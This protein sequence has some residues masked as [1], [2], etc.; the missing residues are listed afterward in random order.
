MR[1][2]ITL[3]AFFAIS[4]FSLSIFSQVATTYSFSQVDVGYNGISGG[5]LL[6]DDVTDNMDDETYGPISIPTFVFDGVAYDKIFVSSNGFITFGGTL[7]ADYLDYAPISYGE[8]YNGVISGFG[9]DLNYSELAGATIRCN[10]QGTDFVIQWRNVAR[11]AVSDAERFSF[12]IRLDTTTN[13]ITVTYGTTITPGDDQ[14]YPEIGIRGPDSN[15]PVNVNNREVLPFSGA[16]VNSTPGTNEFSTCVFDVN[17]PGTEPAVGTQFIWTPIGIDMQAAGLSLPGTGGCYG[18]NE[19]VSVLIRNVSG[20]VHDFATDP[21]T[22]YASASGPNPATFAPVII[23]TG[24]LAVNATQAVVVS[25]NYDMTNYGI[26]SFNA[27]TTLAGDAHLTN[28]AMAAVTRESYNPSFDS[29]P[30]VSFCGPDTATLNGFATAHDYNLTFSNFTNDNIPDDNPT[31]GFTNIIVPAVASGV[32]ASDVTVVVHGITHAYDSDFAIY[33]RAPDMSEIILSDHNLGENY[34][35][36]YFSDTATVP[37]ASGTAPYTGSFLPDFSFSGLTGTANGTWR[38]TC[39]DDVA[40]DA[41]VLEGWSIL[42]P[43]NN[44]IITYSW[45]PATGLS[46]TTIANPDAHPLVTTTYV[47]TATDISGCTNTDTVV[48]TINTPPTVTANATDDSLC[49]SQAIILTGGGAASYVWNNSVMD[50]VSFTPAVSDMYVVDGI[51]GNGCTGSDSIMI[52]VFSNPVVTY[53]L[54]PDTVCITAGLIDLSGGTPLGGVYTGTGVTGSTFDPGTG[55]GNYTITYTYTD[56]NGCFANDAE[57]I[58]VLSCLS[59]DDLSFENLMIYPNPSTGNFY[60]D[61]GEA[62]MNNHVNVY[63]MLGEMIYNENV[64]TDLVN[65]HL[66]VNPGMYIVEITNGHKIARKQIIIN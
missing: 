25:T 15:F 47:V 57:S 62:D 28:D 49:G 63:N 20:T 17:D 39:I 48:F 54:S 24:T 66:N 42:I 41:G 36:T 35:E 56:P 60:V 9:N 64:Q 7:P 10:T 18:N 43:V 65:I 19:T 13:Q 2:A 58:T 1:R 23:N 59:L 44:S 14:T 6:G 34:Y 33:L 22:L 61:F 21:V 16:W 11:Y 55:T 27:Y 38:L 4:F 37:I 50:G 8:P 51:D 12:Q 45:T 5:T 52:N 26:Y 31:G 53:N 3:L 40:L 30:D 46:S 32:N 29:L